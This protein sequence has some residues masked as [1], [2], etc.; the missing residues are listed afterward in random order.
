MGQDKAPLLGIVVLGLVSCFSPSG[1]VGQE[2]PTIV[3]D[4]G[5]K[6][7][8]SDSGDD[9]GTLQNIFQDANAPQDGTIDPMTQIIADLTMKRMRILGADV[10]CDLDASGTTEE[11]CLSADATRGPSDFP[12]VLSYVVNSPRSAEYS[13]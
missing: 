7:V 10:Y 2:A 5:T 12:S 9:L 3:V 8:E 13:E 1:C 6:I 11:P 4:S